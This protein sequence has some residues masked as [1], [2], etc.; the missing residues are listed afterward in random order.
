M[1]TAAASSPISGEPVRPRRLLTLAIVAAIALATLLAYW[2]VGEGGFV[3]LD[4]DAY[5]EHQPLVNQGLRSAGVAWAFTGSHSSNWHPLTMLSHM[6]DCELFGVKPAPIHGENL[7]WHG[8]KS[9][10]VSL[11]WRALTGARWREPSC[12]CSRSAGGSGGSGAR[13]PGS[14]LAGCGFSARWCR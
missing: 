10:L 2:R 7:L 11:G 6:L 1:S 12:S 9:V 5:V 14:R 13:K 4:Y 3:N 8:L